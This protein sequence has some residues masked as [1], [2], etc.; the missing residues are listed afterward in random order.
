MVCCEIRDRL[1]DSRSWDD[2]VCSVCSSYSMLYVV[3]AVHGV[4]CTWCMLYSVYAVLGVCCTGCMQYWVYAVLGVNSRSWQ[5]EI[6]SHDLIKCFQV[7][8][9]FKTR[10]REMRGYG[11]NHHEQL[12]L[13]RI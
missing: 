9:E 7:M 4:C 12:G 6:E 11:G 2:A 13:K 10:K 3:Y 5:G 1:G 8:V